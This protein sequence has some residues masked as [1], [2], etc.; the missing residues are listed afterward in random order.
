MQ[1]AEN[2]KFR[3]SGNQRYD[4]AANPRLRVTN[5]KFMSYLAICDYTDIFMLFWII[6]VVTLLVLRISQNTSSIRNRKSCRCP[7]S[8]QCVGPRRL[9]GTAH[10][11]HVYHGLPCSTLDVQPTAVLPDRDSYAYAFDDP[12]LPK[13]TLCLAVMCHGF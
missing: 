9:Q 2:P 10:P 5:T 4:V 6:P 1:K 3:T 7:A 13:R 11:Q 8:I 12:L